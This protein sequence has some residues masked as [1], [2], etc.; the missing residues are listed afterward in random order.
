MSE[1]R[2]ITNV[3]D[4]VCGACWNSFSKLEKG[5]N[6]GDHV[7]CPHCGHK[8]PIDMD[9]VAAVNA[10]TRAATGVSS[11]F[12]SPNSPT[13]PGHVLSEEA[14]FPDL[15]R[16]PGYGWM[17]PDLVARSAEPAGFVVGE[18]DDVEDFDFNEPT[19]RPDQGHGDLLAQVRGIPTPLS[20][21]PV[22]PE[23]LLAPDGLDGPTTRE[24]RPQP[25]IEPELSVESELDSRTDLE[26]ANALAEQAD[27]PLAAIVSG[28]GADD[29][30]PI[31]TDDAAPDGPVAGEADAEAAITGGDWK[32]RALSLTYNFHGLDALLGRAASKSGQAMQVSI[33]GVVW[34]DFD[35]FFHLLKSGYV[36]SKALE[37]A[38]EP[39]S[40]PVTPPTSP[41]SAGTGPQPA[42]ARGNRQTMTQLGASDAAALKGEDKRKAPGAKDKAGK[43]KGEPL[44]S[45]RMTGAQPAA[46]G[47]AVGPNSAPSRVHKSAGEAAG[48]GGGKGLLIAGAVAFLAV[49]A[50]G[51]LYWQ[52]IISIPGLK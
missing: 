42:L 23:L 44:A 38:G 43:D 6:Q 34:K 13:L 5:V 52:G 41:Q 20:M 37:Q 22:A 48:A 51:L 31:P 15:D 4:F 27:S 26:A 39:G 29:A 19:L 21:P 50:V 35:V 30:P 10:A 12:N 9:V 25:E 40:A 18:A 49:A 16:G 14:G 33:D 45:G 8:M 24:K 17:P 3:T 11:G 32:L 28:L 1:A 7:I 46:A 2:P 47:R 36:A